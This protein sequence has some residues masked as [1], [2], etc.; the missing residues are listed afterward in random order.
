MFLEVRGIHENFRI[1]QR[2]QNWA[3]GLNGTLIGEIV[4]HLQKGTLESIKEDLAARWKKRCLALDNSIK[5]TVSNCYKMICLIQKSYDDDKLLTVGM[6]TAI[7]YLQQSVEKQEMVNY[8]E[9][10]RKI[11][12]DFIFTEPLTEIKKTDLLKQKYSDAELLAVANVNS[13]EAFFHLFKEIK[14]EELEKIIAIGHVGMAERKYPGKIITHNYG[15]QGQPSVPNCADAALN[16]LLNNL[17]Y[18]A[19]TSTFNLDFLPKNIQKSLNKDLKEFYAHYNDPQKVNTEE[20]Q[21]AFFNITSNIQGVEYYKGRN[22]AIEPSVQNMLRV[23]NFLLGTNADIWE[24][25][26]ALLSTSQ[27]KIICKILPAKNE[28]DSS[29]V[30]LIMHYIDRVE[31]DEIILNIHKNHASLHY[32][33]REIAYKRKTLN[34]RGTLEII[35]KTRRS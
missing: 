27:R 20:Y 30:I 11:L 12:G 31:D 18:D 26:G 7:L 8:L 17:L 13:S 32:E 2:A 23:V 34:E 4:G 14:G 25:L 15:F 19:H 21:Q 6:L 1:S 5:L 10:L 24:K 9:S 3:K 29:K 33:M 35:K 22:Y 16:D 28:M